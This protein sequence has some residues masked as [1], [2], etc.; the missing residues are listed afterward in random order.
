MCLGVVGRIEE[1]RGDM[2]VVEIMGVQRDIS[3]VLVPE[4]KVGEYVMI[5]AGFAINPI[6]EAA[7]KETEELLRQVYGDI[8]L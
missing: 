2:A 8:P 5:H 6:D 3:I 4:I 7:A 1:I